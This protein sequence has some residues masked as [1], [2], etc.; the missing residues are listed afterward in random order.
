MPV[1]NIFK[2]REP[3]S[4][5]KEML[6]MHCRQYRDALPKL[7]K[8]LEEQFYATDKR[9]QDILESCKSLSWDLDQAIKSNN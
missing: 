5:K 8:D 6:S 7:P 3:Y 2:G 4:N 1:E 9:I